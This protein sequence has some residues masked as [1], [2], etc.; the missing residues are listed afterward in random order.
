MR[1]SPASAV[2]ALKFSWSVTCISGCRLAPG[3]SQAT[4]G[5]PYADAMP[6]KPH[7]HRES[8]VVRFPHDDAGGLNDLNGA[9]YDGWEAVGAFRGT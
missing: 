8:R 1:S 7:R 4:F 9:G 2:R 6:S 3:V 5:D